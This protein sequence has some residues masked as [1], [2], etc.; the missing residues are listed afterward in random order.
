MSIRLSIDR[1]EGARKEI[2]VLVT[3]DGRSI[4]FPRDLL[5][6]GSK[7][8]D[9]LAMSLDR[10][11]EGMAELARK[12]KAVRDDLAKTDPGGDIQL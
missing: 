5:P 2:A 7:A 3:P 4:H 1:F 6:K 8:G 12:A 11:V 10:D 9:L